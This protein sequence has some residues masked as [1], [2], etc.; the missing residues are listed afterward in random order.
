[1]NSN[2]P[3][4]TTFF[5]QELLSLSTDND[6][7]AVHKL[8]VTYSEKCSNCFY[9][10]VHYIRR[11]LYDTE[12][13]LELSDLNVFYIDR[14]FVRI[15]LMYN[16]M[17]NL[18]WNCKLTHT[19]YSS[20]DICEDCLRNCID[21]IRLDLFDIRHNYK[22]QYNSF[23]CVFFIKVF[24]LWSLCLNCRR[25]PIHFMHQMVFDKALDFTFIEYYPSREYQL[26]YQAELRDPIDVNNCNSCFPLVVKVVY[27]LAS[28]YSF[29]AHLTASAFVKMSISV[30][31]QINNLCS[32]CVKHHAQPCVWCNFKVEKILSTFMV[33]LN[34]NSN[35][36][37]PMVFQVSR[38]TAA[39]AI[40]IQLTSC[41]NNCL[42]TF[43]KKNRRLRL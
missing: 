33:V 3:D 30:Y 35:W 43:K 25:S 39:E 37:A 8:C 31:L 22:Y 16:S 4:S 18:Y 13:L 21:R 20:M 27:V 1:M 29:V 24:N 10:V 2:F 9:N 28:M 32:M 12:V 34:N 6:E 40:V 14:V 11:L 19:A 41:Q 42:G 5:S 17:Y 15:K 36:N 23:V 38:S 7:L 26:R